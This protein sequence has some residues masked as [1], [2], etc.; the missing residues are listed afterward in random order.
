MKIKDVMEWVQL[1]DDDFDSAVLLN[2][3][4]RKHNE[5]ICYLC[6]QSAEKHLRA[7]LAYQD[8]IPEKTHN[9]IFLNKLCI[10]KDNEFQNIATLCNILNRFANDICYPHKYEVTKND[11]SFSIGAVETIKNIKPIVALRNEIN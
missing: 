3:A 6:A 8:I 7:Y 10:E 11:V 5:V 2:G 1:V 9:L 4:V